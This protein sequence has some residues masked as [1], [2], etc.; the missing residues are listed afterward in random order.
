MTR[1]EIPAKVAKFITKLEKIDPKGVD[2]IKIFLKLLANAENPCSLANTK[3]VKNTNFWR[4]RIR[5]YRIFGEIKSLENENKI[6]IQLVI[7]IVKIA[8]R[9]EKTYK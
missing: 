8:P 6:V 9:D 1:I 2:D 5:N 3:K 7:E 4:W